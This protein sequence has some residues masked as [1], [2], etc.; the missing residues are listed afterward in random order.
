MITEINLYSL[1]PVGNEGH[2]YNSLSAFEILNQVHM[3]Q[4]KARHKKLGLLSPK[5]RQ[6]K[7]E[8]GCRIIV[9]SIT[10]I[11]HKTVK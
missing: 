8:R 5:I 1:Q 10:L 4:K 2:E 6:R 3:V 9:A 7:L 11:S